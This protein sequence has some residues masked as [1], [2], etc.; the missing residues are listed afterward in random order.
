[1]EIEYHHAHG[2]SAAT[3]ALPVRL[4]AKFNLRNLGVMRLLVEASEVCRCEALFYRYLADVVA[5][6]GIPSP[7]CFFTDFND[8]T[9]APTHAFFGASGPAVREPRTHLRTHASTRALTDTLIH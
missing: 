1:M 4:F 8:V 9:G 5:D 2:E 6:V 3:A 7:K